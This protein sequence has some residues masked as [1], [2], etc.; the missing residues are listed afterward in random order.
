VLGVAGQSGIVLGASP[1]LSAPRRIAWLG[2]NR[3]AITS[4][5]AVLIATLP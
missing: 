3:F 4:D 1:S 5:N 2:G